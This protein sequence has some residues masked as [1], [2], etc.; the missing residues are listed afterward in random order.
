MKKAFKWLLIAVAA[1]IVMVI[2]AVIVIPMFIDVQKYKPEIETRVSEIT[3]RPFTIGGNIDLS[4]FPWV[5]ISLSDLHLGN[6]PGFQEKDFLSV[7]FFEVRVKLIPLLSRNIQVK[8]FILEGPRI[9]FEK[10]RK[11]VANWE[12]IG[13]PSVETAGKPSN[14]EEKADESKSDEGLPIKDLVVGEF[15]ITNGVILFLDGIKGDRKEIS[16]VNLDLK[17]I[18]LDRPVNIAFSAN[19]DGHPI[20]VKGNAGPIGKAPGKGT[21]SIDMT[22]SLLKELTAVI[23]G[24]IVDPASSREFDLGLEVYPFSP[25]KLVAALG[26]EFPVVTADPGVLNLLA[27]KARVKG[28]PRGIGLSDGILRLDDS[29]LN[30]TAGVKDFSGPDLTFDLNLDSMDLDRYL[31]PP[32]DEKPAEKQESQ[33]PSMAEK[34]KADYSPLRKPVLDGKIRV[35]D[36]KAHGARIQD[37]YMSVTGRNGLFKIDP[38][39]LRLYEG[40]AA[41]KASLDVRKDVPGIKMELQAKGIQANPLLNDLLGRDFLEGTLKAE[42]DIA[43]EGDDGK[44]I[45]S[46]LNGRGD[47]LF[48]DGAVKG[49]DLAGMVRNA[50]AALGLAEK[51]G[52]KPRTDFS[53]L[54]VPFTLVNGLVKTDKT[55]L[56][57]PFL[58][59]LVTGKADLIKE[60]LDFRIEPKFVGTLKGQGDTRQRTGITVPVLVT[61]SFSSPKFRADL[62]GMLQQELG[63]ELPEGSELKKMLENQDKESVREKKKA[64]KEDIKD[65]LKGFK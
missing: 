19:L 18:S 8:R 62:K 46:N 51:E 25:R 27:I 61:G 6:P 5:G 42:L 53:E 1:L 43:F 59:V 52:E 17:D 3:G 54:N 21:V 55:S 11:G 36:L 14:E 33:K 24:N 40:Y 4:L 15:L 56:T 63:K 45:R 30:F 48:N 34:S 57:S 7:N 20:G 47:F 64:V 28:S 37:L 26:G 23:R 9:V 49:I 31:P 13:K 50:A 60:V 22:I 10:N 39:T 16:D 29:T 58:R 65:L 32:G 12:D 35:K 41:S 44:S 2:V 38:L